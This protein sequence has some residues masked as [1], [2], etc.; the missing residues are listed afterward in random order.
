MGEIRSVTTLRRKRDEIAASVRL[1]ERQ[2]AQAEADLA[3]VLAARNCYLRFPS[4]WPLKGSARSTCRM[5][6]FAPKADK[7]GRSWNVRYAP[8]ADIARL[9]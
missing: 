5:S 1:Y 4:W 2:L 7:R 9:V 8:Q 6:A 3:H